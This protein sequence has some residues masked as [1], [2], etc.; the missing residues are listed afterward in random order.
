MNAGDLLCCIHEAIDDGLN[1]LFQKEV[2]PG[3]WKNKFGC[4]RIGHTLYVRELATGRFFEIMVCESSN[5][6]Y[7]ELGGS[8]LK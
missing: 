5:E 8:N 2:D 6:R 4:E 3:L 1:G 7:G